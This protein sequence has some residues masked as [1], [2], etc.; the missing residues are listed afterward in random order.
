MKIDPEN[1]VQIVVTQ[2]SCPLMKKGATVYLNGAVIDY[3]ESAPVCV[4]ALVGIYPWI[5]T[6]RFGIESAAMGFDGDYRVSCPDKLVEFAISSC[7]T[8]TRF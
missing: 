8:A 1:K 7:N 4:T 2:S 3:R 6:A 5:M